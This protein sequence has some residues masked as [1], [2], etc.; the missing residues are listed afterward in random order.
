[1]KVP[2]PLCLVSSTAMYGRI[3]HIILCCLLS[4]SI[5]V[6]QEEHHSEEHASGEEHKFHHHQVQYA[7]GHTHI[8]TGLDLEDRRRWI[9]LASHVLNYNYRFNEKWSL[10]LHTDIIIEEFR[11]EHS[12]D[13]VV[14]ERT[15]PVTI[16]LMAGYRFWGPFVGLL[17]GG[18]EFAPEE[19]LGLMRVGV[20]P[21]WHF[22]D[23]KWEVSIAG[24]YEFKIDAYN[25]WLFAIG[26]SRF[27]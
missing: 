14:F 19:N 2:I 21:G 15:N 26:I 13:E 17:G 7:V 27:F 18:M 4:I 22:G 1:M 16:S 3:F 9:S 20:E 5:A 6:G 25:S 12:T 24:V 8:S 23:G 10:G 11:V